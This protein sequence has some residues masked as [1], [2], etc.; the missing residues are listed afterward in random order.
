[1]IVTNKTE[2]YNEIPGTYASSGV[3]TYTEDMAMPFH[4]NF[5]RNGKNLS[6]CKR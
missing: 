3:D 2:V 1:M 6:S 4:Q 5:G